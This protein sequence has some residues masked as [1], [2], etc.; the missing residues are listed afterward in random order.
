MTTNDQIDQK[1]K[2]ISDIKT[3]QEH[4]EIIKTEFVINGT[5]HLLFNRVFFDAYLSLLKTE[6]VRTEK[7]K[8]ENDLLFLDTREY[9]IQTLFEQNNKKSLE[10]LKGLLNT[11]NDAPNL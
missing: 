11:I 5:R 2:R 8:M 10:K 6:P 3:I 4:K 9:I 7:D 1:N